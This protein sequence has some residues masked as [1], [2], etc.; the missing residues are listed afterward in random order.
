M[1]GS[2][3]EYDSEFSVS[4]IDIGEMYSTKEQKNKRIFVYHW[5]SKGI[6]TWDILL[7]YL[8]SIAF[9]GTHFLNI[10]K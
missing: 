6:L 2:I 3:L 5:Y 4:I 7:K 8:Y 1:D 9:Y 10:K